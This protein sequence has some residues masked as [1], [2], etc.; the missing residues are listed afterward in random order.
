MLLACLCLFALT[1]CRGA[2][3]MPAPTMAGTPTSPTTAPESTPVPPPLPPAS[4]T[5]EPTATLEETATPVPATATPTSAPDLSGIG[6][7]CPPEP[8]LK[9]DYVSYVLSAE[10][11]PMPDSS[12]PQPPLSLADPLPF[13]A[14]NTG[15]AYGS[16]GG[17]RYLLHNGLDMAD[18]DDALAIA[19][20][21]GRIIVARDDLDEM[22]G[23]RCD[24]YGRLV[25]ILLDEDWDG[26]PV[27]ALYG[28]VKDVQVSEGQQ[29][30]RGDPIARGGTAGVAVVRHLHLEIRVGTN[31]FGATRNPA[32][33]LEPPGG[34]GVIA[35]RLVDPDGHA[36]QGVT[37]TLIDRTG[38]SDFIYTSTYLEDP[39]HIIRPDPALAENFVFG[40]VPIGSYDVYAKIQGVEYRR[41]VGVT[42]GQLAR[43]ELVTEPYRTPTP[44]TPSD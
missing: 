5:P 28:H 8:P 43:L 34:T 20:A 36:W 29:V 4:P 40:P 6:L 42:D 13:A 1:A 24:W 41:T 44:I 31:T 22:F 23:W 14:R 15:Y 11:W 37:M 7:S 18:E 27:Y 33:W 25:V 38:R 26:E 35:G 10:V 39:D 9:P 16:D 3:T 30:E 2:D 32:L 19:V 17:G 12:R 21:D